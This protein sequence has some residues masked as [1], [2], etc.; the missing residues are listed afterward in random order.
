MLIQ[1]KR[2]NTKAFKGK[3]GKL[4]RDLVTE[5]VEKLI[6]TIDQGEIDVATIQGYIG[7]I[8][9]K[10]ISL[11]PE[12][13]TNLDTALAKVLKENDTEAFGFASERSLLHN[14]LR[15]LR[16]DVSGYSN[17]YTDILEI[18]ADTPETKFMKGI[19]G[20]VT[21]PEKN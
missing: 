8:R 2:A 1:I 20:L 9:R 10:D 16:A 7:V 15:E 11:D 6:A 18:L 3:K 12:V 19:E 17:R 21:V 5:M 13:I 4:N 14:S